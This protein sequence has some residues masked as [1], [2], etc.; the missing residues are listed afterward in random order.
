MWEWG[1]RLS[2]G[3]EV[4]FWGDINVLKLWWWLY[5]PVNI[6]KTI[7]LYTSNGWIIWYVIYISMKLLRKKILSTGSLVILMPCSPSSWCPKSF[8]WYLCM[9]RLSQTDGQALI[10]VANSQNIIKLLLPITFIWSG[11]RKVMKKAQ[12]T[13]R[14]VF[15]LLLKVVCKN[16]NVPSVRI[17][18]NHWG[19]AYTLGKHSLKG[20]HETWASESIFIYPTV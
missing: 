6:L 5:I 10:L 8:P 3:Y 13:N 1:R 20:N 16:K 4:S 9:H 7:K 2:K 15:W 19:K 18:R 17:R 12:K 14:T 11:R